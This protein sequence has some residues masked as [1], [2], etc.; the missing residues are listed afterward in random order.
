[1]SPSSSGNLQEVWR[2]YDRTESRT[3]YKVLLG[4]TKHFGWYE[5]GESK[6]RFNDSM[7]RM[8]D[9]L[10]TRLDLEQDAVVL[11]AGVA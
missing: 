11:D 8:E 2:Y 9:E 3:G 10:A 5:E 7:R 4:G 1:M 6:W